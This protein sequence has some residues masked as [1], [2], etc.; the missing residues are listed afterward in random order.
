MSLYQFD[1][2]IDNN[3][4]TDGS[5]I[6][7]FFLIDMSRA[8]NMHRLMTNEPANKDFASKIPLWIAPELLNQWLNNQ[9][10]VGNNNCIDSYSLSIVAMQMYSVI[11][12]NVDVWVMIL[13]HL[14]H[15]SVKELINSNDFFKS[16]LSTKN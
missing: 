2:K 8:S 16:I 13:G 11:C 9:L 3:G 12:S 6:F 15:K 4:K 1:C 14:D 7:V 5:A 10:I